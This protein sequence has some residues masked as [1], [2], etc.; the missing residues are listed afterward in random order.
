M[1]ACWKGIITDIHFEGSIM[2]LSI[3]EKLN[4]KKPLYR[5][6]KWP[7][8]FTTTKNIKLPKSPTSWKRWVATDLDQLLEKQDRGAIK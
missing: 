8:K 3:I 2:P 6:S 1:I 7:Q 4:P 5:P